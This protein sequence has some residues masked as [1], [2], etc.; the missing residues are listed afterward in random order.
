MPCFRVALTRL[1]YIS[2]A[3]CLL[4]CFLSQQHFSA[5]NDMEVL[6]E[7]WRELPMELVEKAFF[8]QAKNRQKSYTS[9]I[10]KA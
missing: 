8:Q 5:S 1:V 2:S 6:F 4:L 10:Q 9:S 3:S 7:D